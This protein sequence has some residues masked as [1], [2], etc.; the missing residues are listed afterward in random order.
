MSFIVDP[1]VE[2]RFLGTLVRTVRA[3]RILVWRA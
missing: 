3:R 2:E 1:R